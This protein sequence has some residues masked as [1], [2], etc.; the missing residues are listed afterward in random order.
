MF[1]AACLQMTAGPD[2]RENER[3]ALA[4]VE[5]A[6][7]RGAAIALLPE[8]WEHIGPSAQK[9]SMAGPLDGPQLAPLRELCARLSLWCLAGSIA[10]RA[11]DGR[12]HNTSA[13]IAP[14][15]SIA[16]AYRKLHLFDVDIPDGARYRESK[17]VAA[18]SAPPPVVDLGRLGVRM[19]LSVCYDLRFP[20][21]YRKL[22]DQ[23][24]DLIAVP[25]AFT[26][27][28]GRAHWEVLLRARAIENQAFVLA[29]AQVGR[30]GRPEDNRLAHGH[31][32]A[33]DPWGA[34]LAD[35]GGDG[36]GLAV[37]PIDPA[38]IAQVR[39]ELPALTHRRPDVL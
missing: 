24:A 7:R 26:A 9:R 5:E 33:V 6:H 39:R 31:A 10:E 36:E 15:G 1:L 37:A 23:R 17:E 28:T 12:F 32:L 13:V 20:E 8:M 11:E 3:R 18:G 4:L 30:I 14:D 2:R 19:G 27:Y 29:P 25:S 35:A 38:R 22:A 21:L 16:A 34:V